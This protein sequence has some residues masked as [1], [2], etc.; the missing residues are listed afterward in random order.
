MRALLREVREEIVRLCDQINRYL[1]AGPAE[2]EAIRTDLLSLFHD[3][4]DQIDQRLAQ[5]NDLLRYHD[6]LADQHSDAV[7]RIQNLW[8]DVCRLWRTESGGLHEATRITE[9]LNECVLQIG[10]LTVPSRVNFELAQLRVGDR[11]DFHAQYADE[12]PSRQARITILT[13]MNEHPR[14]VDGVIDV[15]SGFITKASPSRGR[16]LA[17]WLYVVIPA[18][19]ALIV[20]AYTPHWAGRI[21]MGTIPAGAGGMDYIWAVLVSYVGAV[22]HIGVATLKEQR[23]ALAGGRQGRSIVPGDLWLWV[24]INEK[25]LFTYTVVIPI[26]TYVVVFSSGRIDT[27]TLLLVGYSIDSVLD[28]LLARFDRFTSQHTGRILD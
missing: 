4:A 8:S 11:L 18:L 5:V 6:D 28:V 14:S 17:S 16:R 12:I 19:T 21:E 26:V 10:F 20:A 24:H 25:Y 23:R 3:E 15:A 1:H 9:L 13:W 2:R 27:V 7:T 22:A